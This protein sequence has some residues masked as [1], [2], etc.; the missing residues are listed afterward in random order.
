MTGHNTDTPEQVRAAMNAAVKRAMR[1]AEDHCA[2]NWRS[3]FAALVGISPSRVGQY[4]ALDDDAQIPAAL[5]AFLP[6]PM[7]LA[8]VAVLLG[9]T[10]VPAE[11][12]PALDCPDDLSLLAAHQRETAAS[13][14]ALVEGMADGRVSAD[15]GAKIVETGLRAQAVTATVVALGRRA[16][17]Q[18]GVRLVAR[19]AR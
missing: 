13:V 17:A 14:T 15:E 18:R 12:P 11:V 16:V 6:Q 4:L 5:V 3:V 2:P 10:H 1:A 9:E 8:V 7:R 19:A